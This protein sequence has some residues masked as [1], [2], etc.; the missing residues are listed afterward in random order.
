ME[1]KNIVFLL[2][3]MVLLLISYT[4]S[5][6]LLP[7][8]NSQENKKI[9]SNGIISNNPIS[10]QVQEDFNDLMGIEECEEKDEVCFKRRMIAEA[11]LDYIYTQHKPKH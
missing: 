6:R 7:T 2:S 9:E 8:I 10:S 1:Q 5:A 11:H 4:T 3:L